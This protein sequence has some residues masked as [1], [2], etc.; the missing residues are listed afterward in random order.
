MKVSRDSAGV[1]ALVGFALLVV[2]L[3]MLGWTLHD[4][5][6]EVQLAALVGRG[7]ELAPWHFAGYLAAAVTAVFGLSCLT[8]AYGMAAG[9]WK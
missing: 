9:W 5:V 1:F 8:L 4:R 3:A 7:A 6:A 2:S